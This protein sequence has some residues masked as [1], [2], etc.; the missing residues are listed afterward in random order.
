VTSAHTSRERACRAR[1]SAHGWLVRAA[2]DV[3]IVDDDDD[4]RETLVEILSHYGY[5]ARGTENGSTALELLRDGELIPS[6][7]LLDLMMPVMDGFVFREKQLEDP[8]LR[9]I[10][11][12]V[13]SAFRDTMQRAKD[14]RPA[15]AL[16]KPPD[17][18]LLL[19]H[20]ATYC[21]R[22]SGSG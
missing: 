12:I 11:V 1:S 22:E 8:K 17:L 2:C 18:D 6:L 4:I 5:E 20:V 16:R 9:A 19:R 13:M 10:P 21:H 3:L 14:L 15:D 7:I